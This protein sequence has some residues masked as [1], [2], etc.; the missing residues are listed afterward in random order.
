MKKI[1]SVILTL[2]ML[3]SII[4][5][6]AGAVE[7]ESDYKDSE[8]FI[9]SLEDKYTLSG[10]KEGNSYIATLTASDGT[11]ISQSVLNFAT[12]EIVSTALADILDSVDVGIMMNHA[13]SDNS[14]RYITFTEN[15]SDYIVSVD[16][17]EA[18]TRAGRSY[19][20]RYDYS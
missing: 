1:I 4:S 10:E 12:G 2:T 9:D 18:L 13:S 11:M 20:S 14:G 17:K 8:T 16:E 5:V 3:L 19:D 15:V 7:L 6:S